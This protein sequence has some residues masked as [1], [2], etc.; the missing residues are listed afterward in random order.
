MKEKKVYIGND[1]PYQILECDSCSDPTVFMMNSHSMQSDKVAVLEGH[2][3]I[4]EGRYCNLCS[5]IVCQKA[6]CYAGIPTY[7]QKNDQLSLYPDGYIPEDHDGI[8]P[9]TT[10]RSCH[11]KVNARSAQHV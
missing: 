4:T 8:L 11:S 3:V 9:C 10:C 2:G 5:S 1:K 7:Y 6:E